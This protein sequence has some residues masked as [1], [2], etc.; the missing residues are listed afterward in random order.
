MNLTDYSITPIH[1]AF[2]AVRARAAEQGVVVAGSEVIGL[3]PQAALIQ[4]AAHSLELE[5][6]D[7]AQVLETRLE[8]RLFGEPARQAP[9]RELEPVDLQAQS[10]ADLFGHCGRGDPDSVRRHS[11]G[12]GGSS[13]GLAGDYGR[14]SQPATRSGTSAE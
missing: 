8:T 7:S 2:E 14:A 9:S 1:V 5:Q 10:L 6:F 12:L 13:R 4:A 11:R 3:V